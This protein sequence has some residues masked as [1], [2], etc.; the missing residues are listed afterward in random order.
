LTLKN[1]L[2]RR[3]LGEEGVIM[4]YSSVKICSKEQPVKVA[5]N[6]DEIINISESMI[7]KWQDIIDLISLTA[8]VPSTL[9]M[10]LEEKHISVFLSSNTKENPYKRGEKSE[11]LSGLYCENVVGTKS[12]LLVSNALKDSSWKENPDVELNMISYLGLPILW[13]DDK[14][15]GTLC[16]L[17]NKE[18]SYNNQYIKLM[19]LLRDSIE[20]D[21]QIAIEE[22]RLKNELE[23]RKIAEQKLRESET[24]Y[25]ELFNNMRSAVVIYNVKDEGEK[26]I[27]E[28]MNK[29]TELIE[30]VDKVDIIGKDLKECFPKAL[31]MNLLKVM[32]DVWETG[33]PK[34]LGPTFYEDNRI[35]GWRDNYY[36]YKL[37]Q[38]QVVVIYDDISE[39]VEYEKIIKENQRLICEKLEYEKVRNEFFANISH[40]LRTPLNV[41][42]SAL[43]LIELKQVEWNNFNLF[44]GKYLKIMKQNCFRQIRLVN[45]IIEMT[46]IDADYFE[47][48]FQNIDIVELIREITVSVTEYVSNKGVKLSFHTEIEK[49]ITALDPDKIEIILLNLLSNAVKFTELGDSIAVTISK[50]N[51]WIIISVKDTGIGIAEDKLDII[52][53][54]FR[55]VDKSLTRNHEG[56]GIGLSLVKALVE[57]HNGKISVQSEYGK[58]SEFIVDLPDVYLSDQLLKNNNLEYNLDNDRIKKINIEFSD[59]YNLQ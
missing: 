49:C 58:G 25:K 42:L 19:E 22:E 3:V 15:F 43:Q 24:R 35:K 39:K 12:C 44:M 14:V 11:L 20:K 52:F 30:K 31:E 50:K 53:E 23:N 2:C 29:A 41:I 8:S 36:I 57:K 48:H 6:S 47:L 18:N 46:K 1:H 27:F 10:R 26:F 55:Q 33:T 4:K 59:I 56:S 40:E 21:L 16:I 17:D 13:P 38:D 28:D 32:K 7:K 9:I 34:H 54:R 45:N 37:S 5:I 51:Q